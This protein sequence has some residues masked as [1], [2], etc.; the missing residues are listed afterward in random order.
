MGGISVKENFEVNVVPLTIQLSSR[1][2]K[3]TMAFFFPGRHVE[4]EKEEQA[5]SAISDDTL[6]SML[7]AA[8]YVDC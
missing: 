5:A 1:F 8:Q 4:K 6:K 3:K 7:I 2:F